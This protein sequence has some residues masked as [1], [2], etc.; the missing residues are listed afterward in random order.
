[1]IKYGACESNILVMN[2]LLNSPSI[3]WLSE[4]RFDKGR[5]TLIYELWFIILVGKF[6]YHH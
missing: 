3:N 4:T 2:M 5:W 1:M 6:D